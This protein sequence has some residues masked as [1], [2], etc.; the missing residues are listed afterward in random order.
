MD[1]LTDAADAVAGG[2]GSGAGA[3]LR[4]ALGRRVARP[5]AAARPRVARLVLRAGKGK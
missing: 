5:V 2:A 1:N 4:R 3:A